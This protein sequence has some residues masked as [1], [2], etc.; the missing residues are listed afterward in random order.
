MK[1]LGITIPNYKEDFDPSKQNIVTL[2]DI[3]T[4]TIKRAKTLYDT[5]CKN[6]KKRK[7]EES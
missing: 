3:S 2:W 7:L 1:Q 6:N 5:Y 4:N